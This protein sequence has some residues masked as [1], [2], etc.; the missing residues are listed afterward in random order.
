MASRPQKCAACGL[1]KPSKDGH[2]NCVHCRSC[3][4]HGP[5]SI[6]SKWTDREWVL[7]HDSPLKRSVKK[8]NLR[9]QELTSA[10]PA[11]RGV[12]VDTN[13]ITVTHSTEAENMPDGSEAAGV[14]SA[15]AEKAGRQTRTISGSRDLEDS[16]GTVAKGPGPRSALRSKVTE[17]VPMIPIGDSP[18]P[19]TDLDP[20]QSATLTDTA[21]GMDLSPHTAQV[22][23]STGSQSGTS[24]TRGQVNRT[25]QGRRA[26]GLS[27]GRSRATH[28]DTRDPTPR[29][30]HGDSPPDPSN[31]VV[32]D[33]GSYGSDYRGAGKRK[34]RSRSRRHHKRSRR[35][36]SSSSS[37]SS[38][39][40]DWGRHRRRRRHQSRQ[41]ETIPQQDL[42]RQLARL[43][44]DN[45]TRGPP[46]VQQELVY[47]YSHP[48]AVEF[49]SPPPTLWGGADYAAPPRRRSP[50][51]RLYMSIHLLSVLL[52]HRP[53]VRRFRPHPLRS[54]VV[55]V[56]AY[57]YGSLMPCPRTRLRIRIFALTRLRGRKFTPH[58]YRAQ[59]RYPNHPKGNRF[60]MTK[61]LVSRSRALSR[62]L[63]STHCR[64][65]LTGCTSSTQSSAPHPLHQRR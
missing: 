45:A 61:R 26:P 39:S 9:S 56:A 35:R 33:D 30:P 64:T 55:R 28:G 48:P 38:D 6:C 62:P 52:P 50:L 27:Q 51:F 2:G 60:R 29:A 42:L 1:A 18:G 49:A 63:G 5:C 24:A 4:P 47:P 31:A 19:V 10:P 43:L 34:S 21:V 23:V 44:A 7:F 40:E 25:D 59:L 54:H 14:Q 20:G 58:R 11:V 36:D 15:S 12:D 65:A 32:S 22:Q 13:P 17:S 8:S 57:Q 53:S 41:P 16:A 46:P 37:P 3:G